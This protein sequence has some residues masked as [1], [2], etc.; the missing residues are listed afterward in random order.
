[1]CWKVNADLLL[2]TFNNAWLWSTVSESIICAPKMRNN[3]GAIP[4]FTFILSQNWI[5]L[6]VSHLAI[7]LPTV[8]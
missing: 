1:M 3:Y 7:A 6:I 2:F 4:L 8:Q 5:F